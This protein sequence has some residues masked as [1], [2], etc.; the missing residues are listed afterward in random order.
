M[1][2]SLNTVDMK[3]ERSNALNMPMPDLADPFQNAVP[4]WLRGYGDL[5][6]AECIEVNERRA[7]YE[8]ICSMRR[9]SL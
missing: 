3:R 9:R 7:R 4:C 1:L 8:C 5:H 2:F 6:S